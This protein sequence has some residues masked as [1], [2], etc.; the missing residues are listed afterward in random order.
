MKFK[1]LIR[2]NSWLSVEMI[3]LQLFPEEKKNISEYEEVFNNLRQLAPIDTDITIKV[4]DVID[5]YDNLEHVDR[6]STRLNS[7]H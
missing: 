4:K 1:E 7:S 6:K 3:F 2:S 5:D